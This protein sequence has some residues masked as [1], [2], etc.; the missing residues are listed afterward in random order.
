LNLRTHTRANPGLVGTVETLEDDRY[1]STRLV[2][3]DDMAV[4]DHGLIHGGFTFGLA[5][6]AA[7]VLVN[8]PN[9]DLANAEIRCLAPVKVGDEMVA[10]ASLVCKE[11]NRSKVHVKVRVGDQNVA[12]GDFDCVVTRR[13]VLERRESQSSGATLR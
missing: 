6:L 2:A 8:H 11:E 10:E 4:D 13:H 5:D 9:V 12:E 3:T 1:A 7:M